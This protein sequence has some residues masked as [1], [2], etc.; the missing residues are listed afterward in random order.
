MLH[1]WTMQKGYPVLNVT[2]PYRDF[3]DTLYIYIENLDIPNENR[4]I[5]VTYT[6][7]TDLNF[8]DTAPRIWL[9]PPRNERFIYTMN[10]REDG[11][12]ILNIQQTGKS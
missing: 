6:T 7:E 1:P 11:W 8:N 2:R 3:L 4:W 9:H 5:P 10:Y 12:V